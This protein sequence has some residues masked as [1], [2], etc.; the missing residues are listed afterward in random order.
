MLGKRENFEDFWKQLNPH[1]WNQEFK[2]REILPKI[3]SPFWIP[4]TG[5]QVWTCFAHLSI[6]VSVVEILGATRV[7]FLNERAISCLTLL[8]LREAVCPDCESLMEWRRLVAFVLIFWNCG[9]RISA[10]RN[11]CRWNH[12]G[13]TWPRTLAKLFHWILINSNYSR[14]HEYPGNLFLDLLSPILSPIMVRSAKSTTM[15]AR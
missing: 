13:E 1:L 10:S 7:D 4:H 6:P 3:S 15:E 12:V 14:R 5:S 2:D 11:C 8:I 9:M